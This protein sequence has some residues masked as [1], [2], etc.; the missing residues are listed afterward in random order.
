MKSLQIGRINRPN[1][2]IEGSRRESHELRKTSERNRLAINF[3][4]AK[5]LSVDGQISTGLSHDAQFCKVRNDIDVYGCRVADVVTIGKAVGKTVL[6]IETRLCRVV[7]RAVLVKF[8][9]SV[10]ALCELVD[11]DWN[12]F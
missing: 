10:F 7:K 4:D 8:N 11:L 2:T 12:Y 3:L 1:L 5:E 9:R 6:S